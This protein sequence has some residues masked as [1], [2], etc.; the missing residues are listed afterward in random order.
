MAKK[1][2]NPM[3]SRN[4]ELVSNIKEMTDGI[5]LPVKEE[6]E[7]EMI[8]DLRAKG[9]DTNRIAARLEIQKDIVEKILN[10]E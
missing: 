8:L 4:E 2:K 3:E 1:K 7:R 6:I 5:T 10:Q 9:F